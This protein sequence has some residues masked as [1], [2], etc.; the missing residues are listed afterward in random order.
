MNDSL[1]G[2]NNWQDQQQQDHEERRREVETVL[3]DYLH[4]LTSVKGFRILCRECGFDPLDAAIVTL[5][6]GLHD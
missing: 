5:T 4:G 6:R 3:T 2:S 1:S